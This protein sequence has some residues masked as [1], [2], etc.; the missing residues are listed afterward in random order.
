MIGQKKERFSAWFLSAAAIFLIGYSLFIPEKAMTTAREALSVFAV[1]VLPSLA[2][3][4]VCAKILIRAG[5]AERLCAL[6]RFAYPLGMSAGGLSAFAIGAFAGF[7]TGASVLAELCE[8][9]CIE[10]KEAESILP[11]CNQAGA[12]FVIGTVGASLLGSKD[13]GTLLF[14][15]QT[16]AAFLGLC[17]TSGA[18]RGA[19]HAVQ[20]QQV[21]SPPFFSI[22]TASVRETALAMLSV[23]GFIVF[24]SLG[25]AALFDTLCALGL[26]LPSAL[27]ILTGG[28][29]E[30]SSGFVSLARSDFS[31]EITLLFGGILLGFGGISVFLQALDRTE[32]FF[33]APLP[34][35]LGKLLSSLLCPLTALLLFKIYLWQNGMFPCFLAFLGLFFL[36]FAGVLLLK[37][38]FAE[39]LHIIENKN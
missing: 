25:T 26:S 19:V 29:L 7:P 2:L 12:A 22:V 27:R 30:I 16:A 11:F 23:C 13:I 10:K 17:L 37:K 3:F 4:S 33:Y 15:A 32:R 31:W 38:S 21:Q 34:Y 1:S 39:K 14:M 20:A 18:R 8:R 35:F 5:F 28:F 9:G 6:G 36:G 24:F